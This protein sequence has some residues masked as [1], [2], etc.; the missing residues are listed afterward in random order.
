MVKI[1]DEKKKIIEHQSNL[2]AQTLCGEDQP[3]CG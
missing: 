3:A 1:E 2:I